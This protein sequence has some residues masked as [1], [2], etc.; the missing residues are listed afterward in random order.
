[1][2]AE[3]G[4]VALLGLDARPVR[5]ECSAGSGLP[6]MRVV[7]LPDA[8]VR[9]A[10]DRVKIGIQRSGLDWPDG[11]VVAN[12]SPA[13][14]PKAGA[15]F[16]LPLAV[17]VLAA[18]KQIPL[19]ALAGC[20]A[21]GELGLDGSVRPVPG[22]LPIASAARDLGARRLLVPD[23][24]GP[25]AALASGLDV[26]PVA[27]LREVVSV[28]RGKS[29]PRAVD[30]VPPLDRDTGPD[31]VEVRGQ[32]VARRALE[33]AAAGGHH[34]LL[35][36]PPG[37]GKSMLARRLPGIL[38]PLSIGEALE[39]AAVHSVAGERPPDAPLCLRPPF[40][41]P[42]QTTSVAG[43]VGGG[44]GV[45]R[46][47]ELSLAHRGVLFLDELLEVPRWILDA[48]RQPLE[49][50][51]VSIVRSRASV[52]YPSRVLLVAA[53]N[54]CPCGNLGV[55][56]VI[57]RCRPDQIERYRARLSGP[58]LDRIDVQVELRPV[59]REQLLG[60]PDG[61]STATVAARV[62]AARQRSSERW[63]EGVLARD[64][65]AERLRATTRR[66]ALRTLAGAVAGLGLSARSFD[67]CLRV[68]RT[69]ADLGGDEQVGRD[70][71]E[72]AVAYRLP[73]AVLS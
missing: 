64:V 18:T 24:A 68:A 50:G 60:A 9:E 58:L 30:E 33:I 13:A 47:G 17:G 39:V 12:L 69:I 5:V 36:G 38:P 16:D 4:A 62:A 72:E 7:G 37:C 53:A 27:D 48:L 44:S 70:H 52:R 66:E 63:G 15:G 65:D 61:E 29:A 11:R 54:P 34:L 21:V 59:A 25:E 31:L 1:M 3:M 42:H 28:L 22:I 20:Y 67:R 41:D 57:C 40:R 45:A 26:I 56:G 14:L 10:A 23:A 8:A 6:G 32:P 73:D 2:L 46:P 35:A 49:T 19:A 51:T 55:P 71:I 43:L